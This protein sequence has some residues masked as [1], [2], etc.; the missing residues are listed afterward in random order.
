[1]HS[2][3]SAAGA[4]LE[5]FDHL[6]IGTHMTELPDIQ[7][8]VRGERCS[9]TALYGAIGVGFLAAIG[10]MFLTGNALAGVLGGSL[11]YAIIVIAAS[12][13]L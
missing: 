5:P 1:M 2:V 13:P 4:A 7:S 6:E 12:K 10:V 8:L 3:K 11:V 9:D